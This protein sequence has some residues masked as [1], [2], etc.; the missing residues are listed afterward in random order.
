MHFG[1][2]GTKLLIKTPQNLIR[3]DIEKRGQVKLGYTTIG[4]NSIQYFFYVEY[5]IMCETSLKIVI[6]YESITLK[7]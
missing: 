1:H 4:I 5:K 3:Y 2:D 6:R 7:V